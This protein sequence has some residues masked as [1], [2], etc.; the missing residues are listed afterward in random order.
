M[1]HIECLINVAFKPLNSRALLSTHYPDS[2]KMNAHKL[3]YG[4][5]CGM[6]LKRNMVLRSA[7]Y[8][9]SGIFHSN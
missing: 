1:R 7:K 4:P 3:Y 9:P 5:Y 8:Q 2:V 6:R